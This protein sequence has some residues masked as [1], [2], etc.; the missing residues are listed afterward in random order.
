MANNLKSSD[1]HLPY[2]PKLIKRA[3]EL[4]KNMTIAEKKLWY[5]YL[6]NFKFRVLRQRPINNFIVDFYCPNLQIVIEIDGDSHF[7][8]EAQD[9]DI[10][11]TRILESYGLKII[12]FTNN[13]V[14][15]QFD[16]VCEQIQDLITPL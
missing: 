14:L 9:Y 16:S 6:R 3:K 2:N 12:R 5:E 13:Q 10:E 8:D 4:R 11:R 7:T 1:F 15:N